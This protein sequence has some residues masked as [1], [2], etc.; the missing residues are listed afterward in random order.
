M[1]IECTFRLDQ[2]RPETKIQKPAAK[3]QEIAC[4]FLPDGILIKQ[5]YELCINNLVQHKEDTS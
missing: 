1:S 5:F 2:L 4:D 3:K